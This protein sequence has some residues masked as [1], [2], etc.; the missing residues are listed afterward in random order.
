MPISNGTRA[1][2]YNA[3]SV[4]K[5]KSRNL[6]QIKGMGCKIRAS[7]IHRRCCGEES[8][9]QC[10]RQMRCECNP[11]VGKIPWRRARQPIPV[12][13]PGEADGQSSSLEGYSPQGAK[14]WTKLM[15]LSMYTHTCGMESHVKYVL[16]TRFQT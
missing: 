3:C 16:P 13:L 15:R 4:G 1:G 9:C 10:G 2:S 14:S 7:L 5:R 6:N 12:F 11:W 8:A